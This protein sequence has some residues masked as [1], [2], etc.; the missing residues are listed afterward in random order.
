[1]DLDLEL[2]ASIASGGLGSW[3][4]DAGGRSLYVKSNDCIGEPAPPA[5]R[6]RQLRTALPP[7]HAASALLTPCSRLVCTV[8]ADA[9]SFLS[10][11]LVDLY[12][13]E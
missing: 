1:M 4:Q 10:S 13:L 2:L 3:V 5:R 11:C 8:L 6:Q 7:R 9:P 12:Y